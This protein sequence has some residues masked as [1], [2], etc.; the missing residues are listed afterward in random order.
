MDNYIP[1]VA[2][3]IDHLIALTILA[4]STVLPSDL[5]ICVLSFF[6]SNFLGMHPG[7]TAHRT[8]KLNGSNDT[9]CCKKVFF[10]GYVDIA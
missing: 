2:S 10:K 8:D 3:D 9:V 4:S 5:T 6:F 1:M 7:R